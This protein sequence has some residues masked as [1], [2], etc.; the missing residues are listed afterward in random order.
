MKI[1]YL[2][3]YFNT[4]KMSGGTRSYE[5]ARR[6][7]AAGH[8]VHMITSDRSLNRAFQGWKEEEIEGIN[9]CWYSNKYSNSFGIFRRLLAFFQF[10]FATMR[11]VRTMDADLIFATSTPLTIAI[12]GVY[13][14]KS[15]SVP[16]V[17]EV[18]DLWPELPIALGVISNPLMKFLA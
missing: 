3:Q 5:M 7:V 12:P 4:P 8:E 16:L 17:F 13:A 15:K 11:K 10:A 9:V 14:S 1:I 6:L 18:R 2:H